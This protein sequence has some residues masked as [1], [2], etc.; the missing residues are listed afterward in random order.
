MS[1]TEL[2]EETRQNPVD[3]V[4]HLASLND[5]SFERSGDHEISLSIEG[6]R[7]DYH[8]SFQWMADI[9]ALHLGC[10]FDLAI[11]EPNYIEALKLTAIINER[12][13]FGHFDLWRDEK[14]V[15]Y[16]NALVLPGDV[17]ATREQC[18]IMVKRALEALECY[19]PAFHF[20]IWAGKTAKEAAEAVSFQTE[21]EA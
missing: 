8:V 4:E 16:R 5:W 11:P 21:G 7:C 6:Q 10:A 2:H 14:M 18:G 17:S 15:M 3:L 1:R 13:W 12:L 19:Y 9:E 20:V